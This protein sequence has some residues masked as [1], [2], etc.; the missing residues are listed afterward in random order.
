MDTMRGYLELVT[1]YTELSRD[2][3]TAGVSAAVTAGDLLRARGGDA[4]IAYFE[5]LVPEVRD[6]AVNRAVR[7]QLVEL[8]KAAG[9]N[10]QAL[11]QLRIIITDPG[12][13][14]LRPAG[15]TTQP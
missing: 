11:E 6:P 14:E 3:T 13:T 2:E 12:S 1:R 4:A 7:F 9:K 8:Y 5:K 10:D 15:P